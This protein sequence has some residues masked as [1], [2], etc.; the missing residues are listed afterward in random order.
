MQIPDRIVPDYH[1]LSLIQNGISARTILDIEYKKSN[2][3]VNKR[4][5]EPIGL[6]F[7]AFS[8]HMIAWCHVRKDYR[9]FKVSRILQV[10]NTDLPFKKSMHIE[11]NEYMKILPVNY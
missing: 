8:W 9:D 1:Y 6:I 10:R 2:D 3:E 4:S 11:L 7:Y 5:V